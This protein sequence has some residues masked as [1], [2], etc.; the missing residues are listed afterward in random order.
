MPRIHTRRTEAAPAP[1][2]RE[3]GG[4]WLPLGV[5]SSDRCR[6]THEV[7]YTLRCIN[8]AGH[9]SLM[10]HVDKEGNTW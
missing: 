4:T 3:H 8:S 2:T 10:N 9:T 1:T 7:P 5:R 6:A